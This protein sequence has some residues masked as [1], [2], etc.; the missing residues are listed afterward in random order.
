MRLRT[1]KSFFDN[2]TRML[3]KKNLK[4]YINFEYVRIR[5]FVE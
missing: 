5:I 3:L 4:P 1:K 2:F